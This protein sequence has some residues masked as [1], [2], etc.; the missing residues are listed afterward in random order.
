MPSKRGNSWRVRYRDPR[1]PGK[2]KSE[3][4]RTKTAAVQRENEIQVE[5]RHGT[6]IDPRAGTVTFEDF[7]ERWY[8]TKLDVRGSTLANIRGR[9]DTHLLPALGRAP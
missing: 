7:A 4:F 5:R 1:D 3:T 9:L 2:W 8:R 6:W